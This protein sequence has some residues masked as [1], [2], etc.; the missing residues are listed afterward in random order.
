MAATDRPVY[1]Q[2]IGDEFSLASKLELYVAGKTL[3]S[4]EGIKKGHC[5]VYIWSSHPP[6]LRLVQNTKVSQKRFADNGIAVGCFK[7]ILLLL[8]QLT[9]H[10]SC[11]GYSVNAEV[12]I[13]SKRGI[14]TQSLRA[15]KW[16]ILTAAAF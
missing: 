2:T 15:R 7:D 16:E 11:F 4:L 14:R 3:Q 10:G 9:E 1:T 6:L 8:K 12:L 13:S 5:Y